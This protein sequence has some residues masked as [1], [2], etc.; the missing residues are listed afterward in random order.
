MGWVNTAVVE[1]IHAGRKLLKTSEQ[2]DYSSFCTV[3][4]RSYFSEI[5]NIFLDWL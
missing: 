5:S 2:R 1:R 4:S 3:E